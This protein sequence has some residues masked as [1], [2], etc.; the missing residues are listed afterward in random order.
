MSITTMPSVGRTPMF[1]FGIRVH[2]SW[3]WAVSRVASSFP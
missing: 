2:Q 1:A 3:I